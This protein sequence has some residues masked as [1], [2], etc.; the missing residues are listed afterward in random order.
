MLIKI[1]HIILLLAMCI[2]SHLYAQQSYY[3]VFAQVDSIGILRSRLVSFDSLDVM[4]LRDGKLTYQLWKGTH[5]MH[6]RLL[7]QGSLSDLEDLTQ[8][9]TNYYLQEIKSI[10]TDPEQPVTIHEAYSILTFLSFFHFAASQWMGQGTIDTVN[11]G[12]YEVRYILKLKGRKPRLIGSVKIHTDD[13]KKHPI[14]SPTPSIECGNRT[15]GLTLNA[16]ACQG[17]YLGFNAQRRKRGT[18]QWHFISPIISVNPYYKAKY[19]DGRYLYKMQDSLPVNHVA[20]EYRMVG[21][22]Y[23]GTYGTPGAV[24]ECTG[25][26]PYSGYVVPL[27]TTMKNDSV[28]ELNWEIKDE[29]LPEVKSID[30]LVSLDSLYGHYVVFV[31]SIN[32]QKRTLTITVPEPYA[33]FRY[34]INTIDGQESL[35]S[36]F[37][38]ERWDTRPPTS[39]IDLSGRIDSTGIVHLKWRANTEKDLWG[40]RVFF[41]NNKTDEFSLCSAEI[42]TKPIFID[43]IRLDN[44]SSEIYYKVVALDRRGN[45]STFSEILTITK[46]DTIP[47]SPAFIKLI[48]QYKNTAIVLIRAVGGGSVDLKSHTLYRRDTSETTFRALSQLG[49]M[50]GDTVLIDTTTQFGHYYEYKI[51]ATDRS[52]NTRWS[53]VREMEVMFSGLRP[54]LKN[55]HA[56][57]DTVHRIVKF[58]WEINHEPGCILEFYRNNESGIY[59]RYRTI[60][61]EKLRWED[62]FTDLSYTPAYKMKII[63]PDGTYSRQKDVPIEIIQ[64]DNDK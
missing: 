9:D 57:L 15:V 27:L 46:P 60:P 58:K 48:R 53:P 51:L 5:L 32:L 13:W 10:M 44:L 45:N 38:V 8:S 59:S 24:V 23:F 29:Y 63:Y 26:E 21:M 42:G 30:L 4:N 17:Y 33:S 39:P 28:A 64:K 35:S 34:R 36:P 1:K 56:T 2:C 22:D 6:T 49:T 16:K 50:P 62:D 31:E 18:E 55:I 11:T 61:A 7:S 37:D 43:T 25:T 47:P 52:N 3:R 40:Y 54:S 41:A 20:Y 12:A 14:A 19:G